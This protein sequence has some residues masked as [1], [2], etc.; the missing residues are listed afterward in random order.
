[1][2]K[3]PQPIQGPITNR[4]HLGWTGLAIHRPRL[5][6]DRRDDVVGGVHI[7]EEI[8]GEVARSGTDPQVMMPAFLLGVTSHD[9][10]RLA[11]A[12]FAGSR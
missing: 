11:T 1:M 5:H 12:V 4:A 7:G 3:S 8:V 2:R 6:V 10:N 9:P